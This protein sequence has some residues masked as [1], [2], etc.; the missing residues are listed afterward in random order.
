ML[1][2]WV[3][4]SISGCAVGSSNSSRDRRMSSAIDATMPS[5]AGLPQRQPHLERAEPA[6]VLRAELEVV[7]RRRSSVEVVVGGVV[8]RTRRAASP[9]R[10]RARSPPRAARTATC[11]DRWPPSR[12]RSAPPVRRARPAWPRPSAPYAPSTWNH[13]PCRGRCR[14]ISGSGSTAPVLT[15]ARRAD[16][17]ERHDRRRRGRRRSARSQ[18]GDVHA[19]RPRRPNPADRVGAEPGQVRGLLNP[20]V[21]F[22]RA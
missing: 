3:T 13:R 10:G 17:E 18:R 1:R 21:R 12:R 22:G 4:A 14:A 7:D 11:A 5:R 9:D 8:R 16:H 19:Q 20:R 6:R 15:A 2:P